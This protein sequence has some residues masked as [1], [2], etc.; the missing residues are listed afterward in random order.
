MAP[1]VFFEDG[2]LLL[3]G[4]RY[5]N[6]SRPLEGPLRD[7]EALKS[8]FSHSARAA[9]RP[10]NII[11]VTEAT[12]TKA[13][14][15]AALDELAQKV[16]S[17]PSASVTI[18]YSGHGGRSSGKCFLV[19][20]DFNL[21]L[22]QNTGA[23]DDSTIIQSAEFAKKINDIKAKKCLVLL[24]CCHAAEIPVAKSL[25]FS[26]AF[27]DKFLDQ[28]DVGLTGSEAIKSLN[29]SLG[30]GAGMVILTSCKGDEQSLDLGSMSL[31]TK[32][33]LDALNGQDNLKQ[34]GWVRL[35]DLI[36]YVPQKVSEI[37]FQNYNFNQNPVFR[38]IENLGSDDF[39]IC[40]YDIRL[41]KGL[42]PQDNVQVQST[43]FD[44]GRINELID[45]GA[46]VEAFAVLDTM[47]IGNKLQYNRLKREFSAGLTGVSLID[48]GDRLKV[49]AVQQIN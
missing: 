29:P 37:A 31:F 16:A 39:I 33:L 48:F 24:D 30:K 28:V 15:M 35:I 8:H 5:G 32:V 6:W 43:S 14:I 18:Y 9:Y 47:D 25:D 22:F 11:V 13:G 23:P 3:I 1:Q 26:Q 45:A 44:I 34:D 12:A 4:I 42:K 36:N 20:Y 46:F 40:A 38:R 49:F 21:A 41:G 27:L 10:D 2:Y 17:N 7:V 19:P